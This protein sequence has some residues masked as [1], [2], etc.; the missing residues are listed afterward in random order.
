MTEPDDIPILP[1]DTDA[2][3][4][5]APQKS[6]PAV[7]GEGFAYDGRALTVE[8]FAAHVAAYR[9]GTIPPEFVVFHHTANPDASWAASAAT[10]TLVSPHVLAT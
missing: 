10:A 5:D 4:T 1:Y 7:L 2:Y 6:R 3:D 9:F 8:E